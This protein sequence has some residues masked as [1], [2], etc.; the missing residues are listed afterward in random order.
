MGV[1]F[2]VVTHRS[3][4]TSSL[5]HPAPPPPLNIRWPYKSSVVPFS[6]L[7]L[8]LATQVPIVQKH[9]FRRLAVAAPVVA[10]V[11]AAAP[12]VSVVA[13][14]IVHAQASSPV[15][16]DLAHAGP[17]RTV[18]KVRRPKP[19]EFFKK[20]IVR[21]RRPKTPR[22]RVRVVSASKNGELHATDVPVYKD[23]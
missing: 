16:V 18:K 21:K 19:A 1:L 12:A 23:K 20:S 22:I 6:P 5:R 9:T 15:V 7:L 8:I 3:P 17:Y 13:S 2:W 14:P 10:P 11:V 4:E